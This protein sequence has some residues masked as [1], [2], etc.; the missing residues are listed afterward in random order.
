MDGPLW[1]WGA[2]DLADAI[3]TKQ[4]SSRDVVQTHLDRIAEV[5]DA[6]ADSPELVNDDPYGDGWICA[7]TPSDPGELDSLMDSAAYQALVEV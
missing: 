3:R 2:A 7:I 4:V 5:N 6:L 1:K